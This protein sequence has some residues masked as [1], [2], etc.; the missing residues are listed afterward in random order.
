VTWTF[1]WTKA[2]KPRKVGNQGRW[3]QNRDS[4]WV[5]LEQKSRGLT[6]SGDCS[7]KFT[8]S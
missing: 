8:L 7:I 2:G 1:I 4:K 6:L 5:P 3:Y